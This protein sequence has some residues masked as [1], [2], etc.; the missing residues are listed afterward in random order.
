MPETQIKNNKWTKEFER[1]IYESWKK[2][3][4]YSFNKNS[5]KKIYSIDTPPPYV[6]TPVHIGHATTYALMDMFARYKRMTGYEV[7]FPLGLDRNGLPIEMAAEKNYNIKGHQIEREK[8]VEMCKSILESSS[9][10]S[11]ETFLRC[12]ISF[13]SWIPGEEIGSVYFT[14]SDEYRKLTQGTFIDMWKKG[15]IYEDSRINNWCPGCRTTLA[16]SEVLR[17]NVETDLNHVKFKIKN[18]NEYIIIATTRPELL[19]TAALIIYNPKDDRYKYLKGKT[20]ITPIFNIEVKIIEHPSADPNFGTGLVFM[21]KSAGDQDAV[22]FLREMNIEPRMAVGIDG[23]MNENAGILKG[24]KTKEARKK[25]IDLIQ[26]EKL[27][28]KQEKLMHSVP[29]CERSK[30][31]IEFISMPELY[32]KQVEFKDKILELQK[33]VNF[34]DES[35]RQILVDWINSINIDWPVSRRR[36]YATEIPLWYCTKCNWVFV[37]EKGKYYKPWK[38]KPN[39]QKCEKCGNKEFRGE[40]RVFDTWFDSSISPLYILHYGKDP[41]FF[42]KAFPATLRP[43]GKEIIRTWLY[44]TLLK[45]YHLTGKC[46]FKDVWINYHI[47][48]DSGKKLSKSLGNSIDPKIILDKYG[49]EPFRLWAVVEGN[50]VKGDF[51]CSLERIDGAGKTLMKLWNIARFISNFEKSKTYK[52]N[53]LDNWIINEINLLIKETNYGYEKYDFHNPVVKIKTFIWETF[54]SHYVELV[55]SRAYNQ[56]NKFSK[57]E[58]NGAIYALYYCLETLLKLLAPVIPLITYKLYKELLNKDIHL[59]EFPKE[60]L[61]EKIRITTQEIIDF[62]STM[63]SYKKTNGKPL[64]AEVKTAVVPENLKIIEKDIILTHKIKNVKYGKELKIEF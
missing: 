5:K 10:E 16:D 28:E 6:N 47:T 55:K 40:E 60:T 35:S 11:T 44:Y 26:Q 39:I 37:P 13:N 57:E 32:V 33:E 59:E 38:E 27:L 30:D 42:K 63:W 50:L 51:R 53:E 18:T 41:E 12:G 25:I 14:D 19:C 64:N 8:F 9:L 1:D 56:D 45:C 22:R 31:Q 23:R 15:L 49:A 34:Y 20:A 58:Q 4:V 62:N 52:L 48:D 21:S 46:V 24:L 36:F 7:L 29:I 17:E 3:K 2:S 61:V 54:S 43:Q